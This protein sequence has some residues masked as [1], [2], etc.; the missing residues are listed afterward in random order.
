MGGDR[1]TRS[2][3]SPAPRANPKVVGCERGLRYSRRMADDRRVSGAMT[4]SRSGAANVVVHDFSGHPFQVQ[5]ARSLA[6]RGCET[7]HLYCSSFQTPRGRVGDDDDHFSSESVGLFRDFNKYSGWRRLLQEIEYGVRISARMRR[8]RPD[9]VVSANTPLIAAAILQVAVL[10][11]RRPIV[12][13][14]Q[15]VYSVALAKHLGQRGRLGRALGSLF[16]RLEAWIVRS[17][18]RVVVISGDFIPILERWGV[19]T[20]HVVVIEN[21]AP[22]DEIDVGSRPN[23]WSQEHGVAPDDVVLLYSGTL[24]L[25][26]EP[27]LLLDLARGFGPGD[28]VRVVV[29]SEGIG[30]DWLAEHGADVET[31]ELLPFQPYE[32]F[33]DMLATADVLL[34]LL[35]PDAGT[36]SVPSKV[37]TYHCAGRPILGAMPPANLASRIVTANGTGVVAEAGDADGF[38][39]AARD[40]VSDPERRIE[41]GRSARD[42]A[43][44]TF[45][46]GAITS[47]FLNVIDVALAEKRR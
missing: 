20:D 2:D 35:E 6:A 30:A 5:L 38:L 10:L 17:S 12:F 15:D 40:L 22:L 29:A 8:V 44:R 18:D 27:S 32:T 33:P 43:E 4:K 31:L 47:R 21:W 36:F 34:V 41:M 3:P 13:W 19:E 26:H 42:Y 28:G 46:I 23:G 39:A 7:T 14:L 37:L 11:Q 9:V 45:D 16:Q 25:K 24:G 1:R